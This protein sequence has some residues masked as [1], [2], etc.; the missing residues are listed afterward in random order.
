MSPMRPIIP[1]PPLTRMRKTGV[2][3]VEEPSLFTRSTT[4][5]SFL[6]IKHARGTTCK[7]TT[8]KR[9]RHSGSKLQPKHPGFGPR[10]SKGRL[11]ITLRSTARVSIS[12]WV[13]HGRSLPMKKSGLLNRIRMSQLPKELLKAC[14]HVGACFGTDETGE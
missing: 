8:S 2:M 10:G 14:T 13:T 5:S 11:D 4:G 6:L 1:N 9:E 12:R 7:R 3:N